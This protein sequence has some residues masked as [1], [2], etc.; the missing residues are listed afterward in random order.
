MVRELK[1]K[2]VQRVLKILV[3]NLKGQSLK[4]E[5]NFSLKRVKFLPLITINLVLKTNK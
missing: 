2:L 3:K 5:L 1:P 4:K